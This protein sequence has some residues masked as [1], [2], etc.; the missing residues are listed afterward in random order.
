MKD[1]SGISLPWDPWITDWDQYKLIPVMCESLWI[2]PPL[3][4]NLTREWPS[5]SRQSP[6][7]RRSAACRWQLWIGSELTAWWTSVCLPATGTRTAAATPVKENSDRMV[8]LGLASQS[9][10]HVVVALH[11]VGCMTELQLGGSRAA[12]LTQEQTTALW[13]ERASEELKEKVET[14]TRCLSLALQHSCF[15]ID[16]QDQRRGQT[17]I[18]NGGNTIMKLILLL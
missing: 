7:G 9:S 16:S 8:L 17:G 2:T 13:V 15:L 4:D 18:R 1:I 14:E 11:T 6:P 10:E 12:M 3:R 5:P